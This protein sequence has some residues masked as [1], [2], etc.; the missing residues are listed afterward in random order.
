MF[1]IGLSDWI[2]NL[3]LEGI[4]YNLVSISVT[5]SS[6]SVTLQKENVKIMFVENCVLHSSTQEQDCYGVKQTVITS[7]VSGNKYFQATKAES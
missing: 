1:L 4:G 3:S 6:S 2:K 5:T 7:A